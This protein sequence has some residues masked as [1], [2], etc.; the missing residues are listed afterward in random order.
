MNTTAIGSLRPPFQ[1]SLRA[2]LVAS[3]I[4]A[5]CFAAFRLLGSGLTPDQFAKVIAALLGIAVGVLWGGLA[6]FVRW[7]IAKRRYGSLLLCAPVPRS[8]SLRMMLVFGIVSCALAIGLAQFGLE[9]GAPRW[10]NIAWFGA[11]LLGGSQLIEALFYVRRAAMLESIAFYE[12]GILWQG[13]QFLPWESMRRSRWDSCRSNLWL[14]KER[15]L[16]CLELDRHSPECRNEA[17]RII[18][19]HVP[20]IVAEFRQ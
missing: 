1:F 8:R 10:Q 12:N 7:Q 4:A 5:E 13:R 11:A 14:R 15:V 9:P 6:T 18:R 20:E 16:V 2:L 17:D 3:A 19:K